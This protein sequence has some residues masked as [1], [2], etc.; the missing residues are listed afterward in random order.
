M[1]LLNFNDDIDIDV[2]HYCKFWDKIFREVNLTEIK[3]YLQA[4]F[5]HIVLLFARFGK[6]K[7]VILSAKLN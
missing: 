3:I 5:F 2:R 1:S 7:V 6:K 4:F